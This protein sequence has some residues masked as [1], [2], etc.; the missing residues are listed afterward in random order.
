MKNAS[1]VWELIYLLLLLCAGVAGAVTLLPK[2]MLDVEYRFLDK[3]LIYV[4]ANIDFVEDENLTSVC[5]FSVFTSPELWDATYSVED[6]VALTYIQDDTCPATRYGDSKIKIGTNLFTIN[7]KWSAKMESN[8]RDVRGEFF[9]KFNNPSLR[10][11]IMWDKH[12]KCWCLYPKTL[13]RVYT[14]IPSEDEWDY[15][16][17]EVD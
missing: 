6:L 1:V 9:S 15:I 13:E 5:E 14:Y 11:Y 16:W 2:N 4:D 8:L 10:Y 17:K 12:N 3:S 7:D